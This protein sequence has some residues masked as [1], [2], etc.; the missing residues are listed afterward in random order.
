MTCSAATVEILYI[1]MHVVCLNFVRRSV[2]FLNICYIPV[3]YR[4]NRSRAL[5]CSHFLTVSGPRSRLQN[6]DVLIP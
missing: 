3:F 6:V 2:Y 4:F 1:Y 5:H